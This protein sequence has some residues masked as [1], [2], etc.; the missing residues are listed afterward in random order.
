MALTEIPI[1]LSSTP[2]IV[3]G[4]NDTAITIDSSE[5]VGISTN[6][7]QK[8]LDVQGE[9]AISNSATSYWNLNRDDSTGALTISD[10]GTERIRI[11]PAGSVGIG[12]V[13]ETWQSTIDA[14]QVG[15]GGS[16]AGNT[17][18]PSRV[19][20]SANYYINSS[21]QESYIATDEASQYFQNAGT[22]TFKVAPSGT[23]DS[24][25]S[26][27]TA[28]TIDN[29]G[30]VGIG[31]TPSA[32]YKMQ[33]AVATNT[34]STG[35]PAA[36]SIFNISGGTTT[37][38]DGV[39]LQLTNIS[40]A[41]ET[42]WRI[43][44]VTESGNN[45]DLVFNGYGGGADYPERMRINNVGDIILSNQIHGGFGAK[46]TGGTLDW[47]HATNARSGMGY[48][49]LLG[50]AT[51]G[52]GGNVYYH[53]VNYEYGSK[54]GTGN[55]TQIA[56]PYYGTSTIYSRNKYQGVWSSWGTV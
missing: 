23:A 39:S 26:W 53:V 6:N 36:G 10:T 8:T 51:N 47:N 50:T 22:H 17:V 21:N 15:L 4:G 54:N 40:G 29:S 16:F 32:A 34:V 46:G 55:L 18:N 27:I 38:G 9:I 28:A 3:D 56:I 43:S 13:P 35:S 52:M 19:Y 25:I 12:V 31:V 5:N 2:S 33:V 1:E 48:S 37:V 49:L 30:N 7:P 45:G 14:L 24:A 20:L 44:A 11:T 41:K 42:G